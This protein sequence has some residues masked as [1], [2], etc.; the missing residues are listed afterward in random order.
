VRG[1]PAGDGP[2]AEALVANRARLAGCL[3]AGAILA[4]PFLALLY[5]PTAGLA[6]MALALGA[7]ALLAFDAGRRSAGDGA[8]RRLRV[9]AGVNAALAA[10]CV[11][12]AVARLLG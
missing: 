11:A 1:Q 7:T 8:R 2:T 4:A 10:A 5:D 3:L 12:A 6:V 9:A